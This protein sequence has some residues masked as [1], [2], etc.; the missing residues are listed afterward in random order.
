MT[1]SEIFEVIGIAEY[2]NSLCPWII[3]YWSAM[4]LWALLED[5]R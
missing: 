3:T 5:C 2:W 4:I 1:L